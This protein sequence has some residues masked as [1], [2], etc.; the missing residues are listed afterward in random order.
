MPEFTYN[1]TLARKHTPTLICARTHRRTR[2]HI[3]IHEQARAHAHRQAYA[4][5]RDVLPHLHEEPGSSF[6]RAVAN[7]EEEQDCETH[8]AL[9]L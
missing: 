8:N 4:H 7:E 5:A 3:H 2:T 1:I 9:W 6:T